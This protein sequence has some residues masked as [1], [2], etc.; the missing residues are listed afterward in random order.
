MFIITFNIVITTQFTA[1]MIST[2]WVNNRCE[3]IIKNHRYCIHKIS[4]KLHLNLEQKHC[5]EIQPKNISPVDS[6]D[7]DEIDNKNIIND[8]KSF[9]DGLYDILSLSITYN[10]FINH[11]S[12]EFSV[13]CLLSLTEFI[14]FRDYMIDKIELINNESG[15]NS[16]SSDELLIELPCDIPQSYIVT[17]E[18]NDKYN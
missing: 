18:D 13:E 1:I 6:M 15:N 2:L 9:R 8:R 12:K 17:N 10:A 7:I 3:K 14:Q 16:Y 11:L 5:I 4:S